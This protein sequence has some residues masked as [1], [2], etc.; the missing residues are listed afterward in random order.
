[1]EIILR[2]K[3]WKFL[4]TVKSAI[5]ITTENKDIFKTYLLLTIIKWKYLWGPK[6]EL[7]IFKV[8]KIKLSALTCFDGEG[9]R[10]GQLCK[11]FLTSEILRSFSPVSRDSIPATQIPETVHPS[12]KV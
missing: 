8:S 3:I 7:I 2:T 4:M 6:T 1:M 12:C 9:L 10:P 11:I 5:L